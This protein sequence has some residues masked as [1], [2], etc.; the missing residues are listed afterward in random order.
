MTVSS[1]QSEFLKIQIVGAA[2]CRY[3]FL[4]MPSF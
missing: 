2:A 4:A 3:E 1:D